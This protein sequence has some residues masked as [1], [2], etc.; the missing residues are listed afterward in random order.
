MLFCHEEQLFFF[1]TVIFKP[2]QS[3][4]FSP[5]RKRLSGLRSWSWY[6][7]SFFSISGHRIP[8]LLL[9]YRQ[10]LQLFRCL[11]LHL[12]GESCQKSPAFFQIWLYNPLFT[13]VSQGWQNCRVK[14]IKSLW[15][16][17][18]CSIATTLHCTIND[19]NFPSVHLRQAKDC[20]HEFWG[21]MTALHLP[22]KDNLL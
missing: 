7:V 3:P 19:T 9:T 15:R 10:L 4:K 1:A 8:F 13:F 18:P 20:R 22:L 6:L 21:Y 5:S 16:M 11:W 2:S 12:L 14:A 17:R